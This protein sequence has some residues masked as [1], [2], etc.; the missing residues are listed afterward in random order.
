MSHLRAERGGV[1]SAL[2]QAVLGRQAEVGAHGFLISL[3]FT[4][5]PL[6]PRNQKYSLVL[7]GFYSLEYSIFK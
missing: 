3:H 5:I 2:N 4:K 1:A 7:R 6:L